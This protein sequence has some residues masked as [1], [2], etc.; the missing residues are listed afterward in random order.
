MFISSDSFLYRVC[1]FVEVKFSSCLT[2]EQPTPQ[3]LIF[4]PLYNLKLN[5]EVDNHLVIYFA[6]YKYIMPELN[7]FPH[8]QLNKMA[9]NL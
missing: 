4:N 9:L 8:S 5:S 2:D 7:K 3:F 6:Q 1:P